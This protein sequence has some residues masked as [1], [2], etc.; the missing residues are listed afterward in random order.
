MV[1][2]KICGIKTIKD[3]E[4]VNKYLPDYI[5]FVFAESRQKISDDTAQQLKKALVPEIKAVGVF[6][7]DDISHIISLVEQNIIDVIQL[8]GDES[9]E[10]IAQLKKAVSV[11]VNK[12]FKVKDKELAEPL[13]I[14]DYV[15]LDSSTGGSGKTFDLNNISNI[16]SSFFVAGG[17]NITNVQQ[18]LNLEPYGIDVSSG[19]EVNG[20]KDEHKI[21]ELI[22]YVRI[23]GVNGRYG[24]FGGQFVGETLMNAVI[25]LE[26]AFN[27]M[28]HNPEF[29]KEF[30][31]LLNNYANRPSLL[32]YAKNMTEKLGGAKVYLKRE[33]LNHTGSHKINNAIGQILLAKKMG[34]TRVIA[35]TGAGQHGVAT[36]TIAA[37]LGLEC[38]IFMGLEDIERQKLNVFRMKL[39][40]AKVHAVTSGTAVLKDAV[41][42]ALRE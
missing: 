10:Y 18:Y 19:V 1:K 26:D 11:P 29:L 17:I 5:G 24:E 40:G 30:H 36:A 14:A 35:E 41:N 28:S 31:D 25:E 22:E 9:E 2:I 42:E 20:E 23:H 7:N 34:K 13:T 27:R 32:Y 33:D 39:L 4:I 37:L 38:E 15:L 6:V 3:I 16:E 8:H 12:V 21:K